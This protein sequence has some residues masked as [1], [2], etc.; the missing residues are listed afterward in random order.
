MANLDALD[1]ALIRYLNQDARIPSARIARELKLAERTV[2]H[3]IARLIERE[4]I[5]PV[6]VVNP[7]AF[8]YDLS[9]DIFCEVDGGKQSQAVETIVTLPEV[10]YVAYTT[11]DRDISIQALFK[12]TDELH[13]FLTH[14]LHQVPGVRRTRT[15]LVPRIVKDTYQW[16]PPDDSFDPSDDGAVS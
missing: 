9:V 6:A 2:R 3:R 16:L 5:R 4:I 8:G 11:G 15:M 10:T 7:A 12:N 1:R 14:K 13:H